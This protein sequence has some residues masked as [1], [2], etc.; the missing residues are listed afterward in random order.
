MLAEVD[1]ALAPLLGWSVQ[2]RLQQPPEPDALRDTAI[3]QPMLFAVQ[4]GCVAA[5]RHHGVVADAHVGH[6]VGEVAAAWAAGALDLQQAAQVIVARSLAQQSRHGIGGMAVLGLGADDAAP[7]IARID[8]ELAIAAIN[9]TRSVTVAGRQAGAG[10]AAHARQGDGL[11]VLSARPRLRLPQQPRWTRS[12]TRS[13]TTCIGLTR[14]IPASMLVSTV[15]GEPM[16]TPLTD[17]DYWW[18]NV[19]EPVRFSDAVA[20]LIGA[21]VQLF[22]EIGPQPV[23]QSLSAGLDQAR[24]HRP[25]ACW[26]P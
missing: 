23:L 5:L 25:A 8:P 14:A 19:R 24:R 3:A 15:T 22:L 16:R 18:R 20:T 13:S 12:V 7:A 2:A 17:A 6:S 9:S 1:A 10:A 21:G 11:G 4:L 26:A